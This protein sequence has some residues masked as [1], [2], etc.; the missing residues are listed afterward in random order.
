MNN[1]EQQFKQ[2]FEDSKQKLFN[3][4][5]GVVR[6]REVAEDVL[7]ESY[8]KAWKKFD[9]YD[10][11]KKF[12]NWMTT[13]VTNTGIDYN[14]S[15]A[16]NN[17]VLSLENPMNRQNGGFS[18]FDFE[19][20]SADIQSQIEMNETVEEIMAMIGTLPQDLRDVMVLICQGSNYQEISQVMDLSMSIVRSRVHR[21]KK[22]LQKQA[23]AQK[24]TQFV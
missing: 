4:A 15:N 1:K 20:K 12:T 18:G 11:S 14:R 3:V 19:D 13:I 5:Y 8:I 16:R 24:M 10:S 17:A 21:A 7:Q 9:E 2:L 22:Q 6:N 23:N